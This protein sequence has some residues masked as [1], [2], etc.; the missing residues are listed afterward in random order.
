[1]KRKQ[2]RMQPPVY[3]I[4]ASEKLYRKMASGGWRLVKRGMFFSRFRWNGAGG[5]GAASGCL[6]GNAAN[7][8]C[9]FC[10]APPSPGRL[11]QSIRVMQRS[12]NMDIQSCLSW[13]AASAFLRG[14]GRI[15]RRKRAFADRR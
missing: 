6:R 4:E 9:F 14:C 7:P 2:Y 11:R 5:S 13:N 8:P 12:Q 10:A 1:M 3:E 15:F